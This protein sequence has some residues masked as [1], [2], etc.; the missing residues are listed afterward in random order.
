M[1]VGPKTAFKPELNPKYSLPVPKWKTKERALLTK[2]KML[3]DMIR[4]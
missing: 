4:P 1:L 3:C 2:L